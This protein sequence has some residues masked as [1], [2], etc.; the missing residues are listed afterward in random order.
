MSYDRGGEREKCRLASS[1]AMQQSKN[2]L[3]SPASVPF[4]THTHSHRYC[5]KQRLRSLLLQALACGTP[6]VTAGAL[7][8]VHRLA[9]GMIAAASAV[10][11]AA[12]AEW[13]DRTNRSPGGASAPARGFRGGGGVPVG[14]AGRGMGQQTDSSRGGAAAG[15]ADNNDNAGRQHRPPT[16]LADGTTATSTIP[17][18]AADRASCSKEGAGRRRH[19]VAANNDGGDADN[20]TDADASSLVET[21]V[22]TTAEEYVE[23]A[24]AVAAPGE[25]KESVRR[26]LCRGRDG[27]LHGDGDG[28]SVA[29]DWE[30][31]LKNAAASS[32]AATYA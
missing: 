5:P 8:S 21:L 3:R 23:K 11:T 16:R 14:V 32:A 28:D 19:S 24:V 15:E 1:S 22:A 7:Q 26:A 17:Q 27:M 2:P 20:G 29:T 30:R 4:R 25:L 13:H 31:F 12:A 9:E 10:P 6:V 18:S